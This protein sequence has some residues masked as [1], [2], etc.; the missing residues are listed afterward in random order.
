[1]HSSMTH[2]RSAATFR[3]KAAT[4]CGLLAIF[5]WLVVSL[6]PPALA[7]RDRDLHH[8]EVTVA[9]SDH[10]LDTEGLRAE[11]L[12]AKTRSI[13]A[14]ITWSLGFRRMHCKPTLVF[15]D[16]RRCRRSRPRRIPL[17]SLWALA[18]D[19]EKQRW[20]G[21]P[22]PALLHSQ[23]SLF[24]QKSRLLSALIDSR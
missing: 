7:G 21:L 5:C 23:P 6:V 19:F 17:C 11:S 18:C 12:S 20:M 13:P 1:M 22:R 14:S 2:L 8:C 24:G 15:I 3:D 9:S 10:G 16:C 4:V